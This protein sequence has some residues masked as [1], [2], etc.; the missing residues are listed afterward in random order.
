[1][2][3][4]LALKYQYTYSSDTDASNDYDLDLTAEEEDLLENI[5][6]SAST[7]TAASVASIGSLHDSE[8]QFNVRQVLQDQGCTYRD[9][10]PVS[11]GL[12]A[13]GD[14]LTAG[15]DDEDIDAEVMAIVE[16][17]DCAMLQSGKV[18]DIRN[19]DCE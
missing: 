19:P 4:K 14:K 15:V 17:E 16:E 10:R 1:M 9:D 7:K 6:A 8:I 3:S 11:S 12:A 18:G 2:A 5:V 13:T